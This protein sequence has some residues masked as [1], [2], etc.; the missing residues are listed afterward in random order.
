MIRLKICTVAKFRIVICWCLHTYQIARWQYCGMLVSAY[1]PDCTVSVLW[2]AV[3]CIPT[4]LHGFSIVVSWCLHTYQTAPS[5]VEA[6][7][8]VMWY[9]MKKAYDFVR[10]VVLCNI[11]VEFVMPVKLVRLIKTCHNKV[12]SKVR[13]A[14][15]LIHLLFSTVWTK[16]CF[17]AI[18][19]KL[20]LDCAIWKAQANQEG[21]KL[22]GTHQ[23]LFCTDYANLFRENISPIRNIETLVISSREVSLDVNSEKTKYVVGHVSWAE[24][25]AVSQHRDKQQT[26]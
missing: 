25:K 1:L 10:T 7:I 4:R 26:R 9:I 13:I 8:W 18:V 12:C 17:I 3:V 2:Y 20:C 6:V 19:F 11:L 5:Q 21:S 24:C 16:R 22:N 15:R 23:L 14:R